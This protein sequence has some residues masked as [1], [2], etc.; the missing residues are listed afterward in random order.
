VQLASDGEGLL[1]IDN[2]TTLW[3]LPN[4]AEPSQLGTGYTAAWFST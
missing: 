4:G 3:Y 2:T 1:W